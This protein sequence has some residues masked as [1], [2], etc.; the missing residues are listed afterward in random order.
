MTKLKL[1]K[2]EQI[3]FEKEG[4]INNNIFTTENI[5]IDIINHILTREDNNYKYT[6]DFKKNNAEII[7]KEQNYILNINLTTNN[8]LKTENYLEIKYTIE[9]EEKVNNTILL[10]FE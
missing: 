10:T 5:Q 9:I 3:V 6:L 7:L 2:N 4:T 8:I 1:L